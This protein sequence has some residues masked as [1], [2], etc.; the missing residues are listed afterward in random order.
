MCWDMERSL[1]II[2]ILI[3]SLLVGGC[4]QLGTTTDSINGHVYMD[5]DAISGA[6]VEAISLGTSSVNTTTDNGRCLYFKH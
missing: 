1:L 5:G 6:H 4:I 3:S 2:C